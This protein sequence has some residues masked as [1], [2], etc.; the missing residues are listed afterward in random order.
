MG[1]VKNNSA[2]DLRHWQVRIFSTVWITYF[3]YYLC[4]YNMP[5][6]KTRLCQTF[7]WDAEHIGIIFTAPTLMYDTSHPGELIVGL[8]RLGHEVTPITGFGELLRVTF[9]AV[10]PGDTEL[11]LKRFALLGRRAQSQ[12]VEARPAK[13]SVQ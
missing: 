3:A 9:E 10:A 12:R 6:A 5:M 2:K 13:V 7:A 4:R 8:A 1:N 11:T